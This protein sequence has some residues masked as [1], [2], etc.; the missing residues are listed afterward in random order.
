[1]V[2]PKEIDNVYMRPLKAEAINLVNRLVQ[3]SKEG[4]GVNPHSYLLLNS[5][6]LISMATFG[7]TFG[8]IEDPG[9]LELSGFVKKA[10]GL[11]SIEHDLSNFLP[12]MIILDYINGKHAM[13]KDFIDKERDPLFFKLMAEAIEKDEKN[14]VKELSKFDLSE[15]EKLLIIGKSNKPHSAS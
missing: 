10:T 12:V 9:F 15:D 13:M 1:M 5:L 8:S 14:F 11:A 2:A 6:N 3:C 4:N 7:K